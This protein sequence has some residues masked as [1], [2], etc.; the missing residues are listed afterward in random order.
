MGEGE[1]LPPPLLT[2]FLALLHGFENG[3]KPLLERLD[4]RVLP[5]QAVNFPLLRANLRLL[6]FRRF[7]R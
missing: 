5:F 3:G 4:F 2:R 7:H 6:S 1:E